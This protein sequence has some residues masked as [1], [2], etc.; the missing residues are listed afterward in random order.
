MSISNRPL[1]PLSLRG[2][3]ADALRARAAVEASGSGPLLIG[4]ED[5][6]DAERVA[7]H[8]HERHRAAGPFVVVD[9]AASAADVERALFGARRSARAADVDLLSP[10]A[11]L[12]ASAGGTVFLSRLAEL[13]ALEQRRLARVLRDGEAAVSGRER[14]RPIVSVIASTGPDPDRAVAEGQLRA[15]LLRRFGRPHLVLPPLR[16]RSDFADV[17]RGAVAEQCAG[18]RRTPPAFTQAAVTVLAA[19]PWPGNLDELRRTLNRLLRGAGEGP[20]RQEEVLAALAGEGVAARL[21]PHVSLREARRRFE[22]DYIAAVLEEHQW[23]MS[24]AARTLGIERANLYRK[25]RQLGLT[26]RLSR[27]VADAS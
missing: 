14:V 16:G 18:D 9:C 8:V 4:A 23:R 13:P 21:R 17:L 6:L 20:I 2:G 3:S 5:G 7:R 12:I 24:D 27:K 25:A 15:D 26:P 10:R 22:Q 19:L 1:L 11:A